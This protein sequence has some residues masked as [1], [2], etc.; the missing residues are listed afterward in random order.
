M[1]RLYVMLVVAVSAFMLGN[2]TSRR[3]PEPVI[4]SNALPPTPFT[5]EELTHQ[6]VRQKT[7]PMTMTL[8]IVGEK[9]WE[10]IRRSPEV[11]GFSTWYDGIGKCQ[12]FIPEGAEIIALPQGNAGHG[13]AM[14]RF[15]ADGD[16]LAHEILHCLRGNWHP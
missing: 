5:E 2:L 3:P 6:F 10:A 8:H 4:E 14:W 15:S 13:D 12:I 11:I 7:W 9:E 16:L 1:R